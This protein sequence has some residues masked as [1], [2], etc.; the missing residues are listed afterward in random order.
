[1]TDQVQL[2]VSSSLSD[3]DVHAIAVLVERATE[4][5][6]ARPL[7]DHVMLHLLGDSDERFLHICAWQ[8]VQLTGYA[9]IDRT[10]STG[11]PSVEIAVDTAGR[12]IGVGADLLDQALKETSGQLQLWAHG[13]TAA[14]AS[15]AQSRGFIKTRELYRM[16]RPLGPDVADVTPLPGITIRPFDLTKDADAWLELNARTFADLPDQGHWTREDLDLRLA[17]DWFDPG[18]FL[19]AHEVTA[20]GREGALVGCH[21]TKVHR[22]TASAG[23]GQDPI[24]EVYVLGVDPDFH[25]KGLGRTL[26][27]AGL[28]HLWNQGLHEV[29]LYVE[30]NNVAALATYKRLGFHRFDTDALYRSPVPARPVS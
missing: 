29:M 13:Q 3:A 4:L 5:D 21:W 20:D 22:N 30:S 8:G 25:G 16:G 27:L 7:S 19:L 9:C 15:L 12:G 17:E 26:T 28:N 2:E 10:D 11:G 6:G 23:P 24:G 18:G 1:M 14:A